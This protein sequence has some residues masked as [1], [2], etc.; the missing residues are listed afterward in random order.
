MLDDELKVVAMTAFK[1][2]IT[3]QKL[4]TPTSSMDLL[5]NVITTK[6]PS[7]LLP[8]SPAPKFRLTDLSRFERIIED[9]ANTWTDGFISFSRDEASGGMMIWD[10]GLHALASRSGARPLLGAGAG[11][12]SQSTAQSGGSGGLSG[13]VVWYVGVRRLCETGL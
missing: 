6:M 13:F 5:T 10:L 2:L 7:E 9:L 8:T 1:S 12:D 3:S 4:K 11:A